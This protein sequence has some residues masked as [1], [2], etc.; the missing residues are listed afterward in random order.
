M[1]VVYCIGILLRDPVD[2][3]SCPLMCIG[4]LRILDLANYVV[5]GSFVPWI[6]H[7]GFV[8]ESYRILNPVNPVLPSDPFFVTAHVCL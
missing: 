1:D 7:Q 8:M 6:L 2:P 4:I 5:V 3:G